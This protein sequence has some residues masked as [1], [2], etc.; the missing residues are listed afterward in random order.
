M[1]Y[2]EQELENEQELEYEHELEHA[3]YHIKSRSFITNL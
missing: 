1:H 3:H 2:H